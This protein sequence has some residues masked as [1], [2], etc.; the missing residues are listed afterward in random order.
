MKEGKVDRRVKYT[1]M[2]LCK[3]LLELMK[4][5][6]INK[7]TVTDIC[8]K[9]DINR[10]TFYTHYAT[11]FDLL[12]SIESSLYEEIKNTVERSLNAGTINVLL[13]EICQSIV[14]NGDM[15]K[16][17]FSEHGN[18]NFLKRIVYI[19]HD[20]SIAIW[21]SQAKFANTKLLEDLY[22]FSSNG[23]VAIIQEWV[24]N[25]MKE[26]PKDIAQFIEKAT[27]AVVQTFL[28]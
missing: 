13:L 20:R 22:T 5:Q 17:L 8:R 6:P 27:D 11:Q 2:V 28:I 10:N 15:C 26:S 9:A 19:A 24:I 7:I 12:A 4:E 23:S 21:K 25:G 14:A 16:I 3:S 18:K 1:K